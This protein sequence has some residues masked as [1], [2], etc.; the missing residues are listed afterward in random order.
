M[1]VVVVMVVAVVV[2]VVVVVEVVAAQTSPYE[3]CTGP[4]SRIPVYALFR[5]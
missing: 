3:L 2:A 1:V 5:S 4:G